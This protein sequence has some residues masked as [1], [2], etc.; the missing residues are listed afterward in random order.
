VPTH[1][2]ARSAADAGSARR[3]E[4]VDAV[5]LRSWTRNPVM[6]TVAVAGP[7][8]P[9][10]GGCSCARPCPRRWG[11]QGHPR[12]RAELQPGADLG[13]AGRRREA[14][15]QGS[16]RVL[17]RPHRRDPRGGVGSRRLQSTGRPSSGQSLAPRPQAGASLRSA[18]CSSSTRPRLAWCHA[19]E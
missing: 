16:A 19:L 4:R 3:S 9:D 18:R 14:A 17:H 8:T 11:G 10:A 13:A 5:C 6:P 1:D 12:R 7:P 2:R 15:G